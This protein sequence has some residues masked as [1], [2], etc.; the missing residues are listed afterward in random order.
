MNCLTQNY[1]VFL[2]LI[3]LAGYIVASSTPSQGQPRSSADIVP[4][5]FIVVLKPGFV[6][7][8]VARG[9]NVTADAV[10]RF[11]INGF[12][13]PATALQAQALK[14]DSR[15]KSVE[16][17]RRAFPQQSGGTGPGFPLEEQLLPT[18]IDRIDADLSPTAS[19]D[20]KDERVDADIAIID[21]GLDLDHPD[22]N[23]VNGISFVQGNVNGDDD[24]GHGTAGAGIVAALDNNIGVVGVAPGARLWSVKIWSPSQP[25]LSRLI[26]GVDYVTQHAQTIDVA[27][28]A[29]IVTSES[30][31]L[32][33]AIAA[34][35]RAGVTYVVS[36]G[37]A[38]EDLDR[39]GWWPSIHPDVI[40]VSAI[41]DY[42]GKGGGKAGA[43]T[44]Q[45]I[46]ASPSDVDDTFADFSNFGTPVDIAAPGVCVATTFLGGSYVRGSGTS[47][48]TVHVGGAAALYIASQMKKNHS[49][50][51]TPAAVRGALLQAAKKQ[52][53]PNFGF[54]GDPDS[55][56]EP[57]VYAGRF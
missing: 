5:R 31:A 1:F 16:P 25:V 28:I 48:A 41:A 43:S 12:A 17:D 40:S 22:L 29:Q 53:D 55:S 13:G 49:Q 27:I 51:P 10:Y 3:A 6:P 21:T 7:E 44:C 57:L 2:A 32:Q 4:G 37:N 50:R 20:G 38:S 18:G 8:T 42:D 45:G 14:A 11:A 36:A 30:S 33:E 56:A 15:V 39:L 52:D 47:A 23:V 19:I 24:H 46:G 34:S 54:T 9:H 35:V 26:S